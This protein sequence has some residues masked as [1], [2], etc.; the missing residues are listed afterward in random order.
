[1]GQFFKELLNFLPQKLSQSSQKIWVWD[2]ESGKN[3]FR[4]PDP[5]V[6]KDPQHCLQDDGH[7]ELFDD[8]VHHL[9]GR[10]GR[11]HLDAHARPVRKASLVCRVHLGKRKKMIQKGFFPVLRIQIH[12]DP[13]SLWSAKSG[14]GS[15]L[16][17]R[18]RIQ[19]GQNNPQKLRNSSFEVPDVHF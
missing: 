8:E 5:K 3:L 18:I 16:G 2:P 11:R 13:N 15:A 9:P 10:R 14:H 6:R 1:M 12:T 7:V 19:E 17:I 4:I